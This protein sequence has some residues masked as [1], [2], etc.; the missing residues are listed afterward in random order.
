MWRV[1]F[2]LSRNWKVSTLEIRAPA[3]I[4]SRALQTEVELQN[5]CSQL[6]KMKSTNYLLKK[7]SSSFKK[8]NNHCDKIKEA[9]KEAPGKWSAECVALRNNLKAAAAGIVEQEQS[10][11]FL[12]PI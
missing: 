11:N 8:L 1:E 10:I 5:Q 2:Y 9:T 7:F 6:E 4:C 12:K 3:N